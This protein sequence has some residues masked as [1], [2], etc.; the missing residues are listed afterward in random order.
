MPNT[1]SAAGYCSLKIHKTSVRVHVFILH[2]YIVF[3]FVFLQRNTLSYPFFQKFSF[4]GKVFLRSVCEAV[5][6]QGGCVAQ[7]QG[8]AFT[9][10]S[11]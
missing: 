9:V 8:A 6:K 11:I 7:L 1:D 5:S 3:C 10:S 2:T 4:P